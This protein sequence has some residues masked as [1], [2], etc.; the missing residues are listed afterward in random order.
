MVCDVHCERPGPA[1]CARGWGTGQ[2]KRLEWDITRMQ[3]AQEAAG[4]AGGGSYG[5]VCVKTVQLVEEQR[6]Y[7]GGE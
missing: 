1:R 4:E 5:W 2:C 3:R 6:E 7:L